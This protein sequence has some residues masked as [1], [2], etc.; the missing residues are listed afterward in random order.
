MDT[1][2]TTMVA[3]A[4]RPPDEKP[5]SLLDFIDESSIEE[6]RSALKETIDLTQSARSSFASSIRTFDTSRQALKSAI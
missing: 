4:L 1:L 6:T 5:R 3:S 2:R